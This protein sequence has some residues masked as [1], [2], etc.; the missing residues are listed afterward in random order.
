MFN[1][2]YHNELESLH[3]G[4][5]K[6]RAYF[7]PYESEKKALED[8]RESSAYL[9]SL[10]GEWDFKFYPSPD[11]IENFLSDD[12][13]LANADKMNVPRS[14]QT[15]LGKGY[16]IPNYTNHEY[17]FPLGPLFIQGAFL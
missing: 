1:Y 3:I 5:E 9:I 2:N 8:N 7:I 17:P 4:C 11:M 14:W 12:F 10:C 16:D 6:P 13:S 15:S